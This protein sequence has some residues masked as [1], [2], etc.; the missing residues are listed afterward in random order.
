VRRGSNPALSV[1]TC[2]PRQRGRCVV[3]TAWS[4]TR[5]TADR[6]HLRELQ[7]ELAVE[8][9]ELPRLLVEQVEEPE[10]ATVDC[11]DHAA[12][13]LRDAESVGAVHPVRELI[14]VAQDCDR[15]RWAK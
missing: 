9:G 5:S 14:A 13:D 3:T 2:D 7:D 15:V 8:V 6:G 10:L 12:L 11:I 1:R 4:R